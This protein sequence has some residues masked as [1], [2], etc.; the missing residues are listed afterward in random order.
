MGI[1]KKVTFPDLLK[2]MSITLKT[3]FKPVVTVHYPFEKVEP[4]KRFRGI[5]ALKLNPDGSYRCEAC[6]LCA[7]MCPSNVIDMEMTEGKDGRKELV[8]FTVDLT[9]CLFCG[10]CVEACPRDAI[11]MT[12]IYEFSKYTK[13]KLILHKDDLLE[14]GRYYQEWERKRR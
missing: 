6:F 9:R 7:E 10:L 11:V 2:G 3:M 1:L 14:L 8:D 4:R 13:D 12:D 5:H